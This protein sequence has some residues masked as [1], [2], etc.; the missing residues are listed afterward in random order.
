MSCRG[1][2]LRRIEIDSL[3]HPTHTPSYTH[4]HCT[5]RQRDGGETTEKDRDKYMCLTKICFNIW[6]GL[7]KFIEQISARDR[8]PHIEFQGS[9]VKV[10]DNMNANT[11]HLDIQE[12]R[13]MSAAAIT[14]AGLGGWGW[15]PGSMQQD[16]TQWH[17]EPQDII[18]GM[19]YIISGRTL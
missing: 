1:A 14:G 4:T 18:I 3:C 15:A 16:C 10:A 17:T 9:V 7:F 13:V 2:S 8:F 12:T 5:C 6:R 11:R 19:S